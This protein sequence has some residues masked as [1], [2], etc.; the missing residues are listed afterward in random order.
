MRYVAHPDVS[1]ITLGGTAVASPWRRLNAETA[2]S[3]ASPRQN[4]MPRTNLLP[5][6]ALSLAIASTLSSGAQQAAAPAQETSSTATRISVDARL[7]NLPVTIRDKKGALVQNLSKADFV[8]TV[9]SH[10]EA[11][12]YFDHDQNLP[13]ILGLL[14]DT[15]QSQRAVLDDE[16][17]ASSSFLDGMLTAPANR[18]PDE[19]F[20]LQFAR[21]AEL[22]Q[23]LTSSRPKLQAALKE[24][25][26]PSRNETQDSQTDSNSSS[27]DQGRHGGGRHRGGGTALYDAIFLS[28]DELMSKQHGRKALIILSDGVDNGSKE[29]LASAIE[30]AQRADTIVYA[31]YFKGEQPSYGGGGNGYPG[32]NRGGVGF[33]GG[34]YPGGGSRGGGQRGGGNENRVD[35]KKILERVSGETGGRLFEVSKKQTVDGIYKQ[36]AEELR[37]QYRLGFTPDAAASAEGYH[38]IDLSIPQQKTLYLQTRDGYYTGK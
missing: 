28:S 27:G 17:T 7:V 32:G 37:S 8:L 1:R 23:D 2:T 19:A 21:Q 25:D 12:R 22:L 33:P 34:G 16:R 3:R 26:T 10:P 5:K 30:A 36:I 38:Q 4:R 24:I 18:P 20:V 35:G 15:S 6:L 11:I 9:D 13:L 29:S 31:I 14:V